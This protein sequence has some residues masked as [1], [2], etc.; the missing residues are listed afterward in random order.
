MDEVFIKAASNDLEF[1]KN[2]MTYLEMVDESKKSLLHYAVSGSAMD[3]ISFLLDLNI[4]VNLKDHYGETPLFDCVRKGKIH[5]AKLLI[6]KL[7]NVNIENRN[8]EA[9]I[10]LACIK[11][12]I[13]MIKLLIESGALL[14][15]ETQEGKLPIHY[16]IAGGQVDLIDYILKLSKQSYD[17]KDNSGLTLLHHA[18]KTSNIKLIEKLLLEG[19]DPNALN[20]LF[21]TPL[22]NAVRFGT[23]D[24]VKLLLNYD[25][26]LDI[27]N[28]RYE[29]PIDNAMIF[30]KLDI[31]D[32]LN[33]YIQTPKYE[34]LAKKQA[35]AIAVLNRDHIYLRKLVERQILLKKDRLN[36]TAMDYAKMYHLTLCANILKET[37]SVL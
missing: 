28:R 22:F 8:Q 33:D 29:T 14:N 6:F 10:H 17:L 34:N 26:Y 31:L 23:L 36:K 32:Y 11:G 30:N 12:D 5:I 37:E 15:K 1:V 16:A 18:A 27:K 7:A 4:S 20:D 24:T 9:P 25:A 2:N 3:V 13:N 21:E 35:L 19:L